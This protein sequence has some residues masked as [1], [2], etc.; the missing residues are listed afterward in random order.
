MLNTKY[1]IILII[2]QFVPLGYCVEEYNYTVRWTNYYT[3]MSH[4]YIQIIVIIIVSCSAKTVWVPDALCLDMNDMKNV[5]WS[6]LKN[7]E[8]IESIELAKYE[9]VFIG[10]KR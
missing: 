7:C 3:D 8:L 5:Q 9:N 10:L 1:Y 6:S 4:L 2:D